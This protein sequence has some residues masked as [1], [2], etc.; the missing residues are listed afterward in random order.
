MSPEELPNALH[1]RCWLDGRPD[2]DGLCLV[3]RP[4]RSNCAIV[5]S[6]AGI[7]AD[8]EMWRCSA[9]PARAAEPCADLPAC[10]AGTSARSPICSGSSSPVIP[11]PIRWFCARAHSRSPPLDPDYPPDAALPVDQPA[12]HLPRSPAPC[13]RPAFAVRT[14]P[15]RCRGVGRIHVLLCRRAHP[16][17][18]AAAVLQASR[19]GEALRR[20]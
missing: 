2:A 1:Q 14:D 8:F 19:H 13:R 16:A 9:A 10:S 6:R 11:S 12:L 17:L 4:S 15:R 20:R 3:A 5:A 7:G 18:S